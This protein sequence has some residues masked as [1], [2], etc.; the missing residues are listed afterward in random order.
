MGVQP[1]RGVGMVRLRLRVSGARANHL[2]GRAEESRADSAR[3]RL[4]VY[5]YR[6]SRR[7]ILTIVGS[8]ESKARSKEGIQSSFRISKY[9]SA[10]MKII[11]FDFF[12]LAFSELQTRHMHIWS[13]FR[14]F[15]SVRSMRFHVI[16]RVL[17]AGGQPSV[18]T[19]DP[20]TMSS[21]I[22]PELRISLRSRGQSS[23]GASCLDPKK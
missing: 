7:I 18:H 1:I 16:C 21:P 3:P 23:R 15:P 17:R 6:G 14:T 12:G 22:G 20:R 9:Q 4:Q 19:L 8:R 5:T 11:F 2:C 10:K 13:S